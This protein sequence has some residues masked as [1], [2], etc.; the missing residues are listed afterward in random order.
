MTAESTCMRHLSHRKTLPV[1]CAGARGP[2]SDRSSAP[3]TYGLHSIGMI[4]SDYGQPARAHASAER[5]LSAALLSWLAFKLW[6]TSFARVANGSRCGS[7]SLIWSSLGDDKERRC[8]RGGPSSTAAPA[9]GSMAPK[10]MRS[11]RAT[12]ALAAMP[13]PAQAPQLTL[14]LAMPCIQ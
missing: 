8:G 12:P 11:M 4:Q 1:S 10:P 5:K 6:L 13:L 14:A 9:L 2:P 3:S 7:R